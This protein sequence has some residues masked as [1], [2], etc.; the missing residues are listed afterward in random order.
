MI[1]LFL[2]LAIQLFQVQSSLASIASSPC[3]SEAK[4][5][6]CC[7]GEERCPCATSAPVKETKAPLS[8][9]SSETKTQE[10]IEP[11]KGLST[12]EFLVSSSPEVRA[13][14][15]CGRLPIGYLGVSLSVAFCRFVI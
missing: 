3:V 9:V 4:T 2:V 11:S 5:S 14:L 10:F 6:C 8:P 7:S 13:P 15:A 12:Q 1:G